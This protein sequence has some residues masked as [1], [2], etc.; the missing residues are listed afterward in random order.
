MANLW[1]KTKT[2]NKFLHT[3]ARTIIIRK[4]ARCLPALTRLSRRFAHL[5][6]SHVVVCTETKGKERRPS[7]QSL[8]NQ[9]TLTTT[10]T[11]TTT[12]I[13]ITITDADMGNEEA[14]VLERE[15]EAEPRPRRRKNRWWWSTKVRNKRKEWKF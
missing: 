15:A 7:R 10:A 6:Y 3:R 1:G 4:R 5:A 14:R 8:A 12:A 13:F 11:A 2:R 9:E